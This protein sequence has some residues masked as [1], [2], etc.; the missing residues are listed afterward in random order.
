MSPRRL[1]SS[2]DEVSSPPNTPET[3]RSPEVIRQKDES[4]LQ[5]IDKYDANRKSGGN[6]ESNCLVE[7]QVTQTREYDALERER[8]PIRS[9]INDLA[10]RSQE[11]REKVENL[12]Y[13]EEKSR[14]SFSRGNRTEEIPSINKKLTS[15]CMMGYVP[16]GVVN[17]TEEEI[18][19]P[20]GYSLGIAVEVEIEDFT[21]LERN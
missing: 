19:L 1:K 11:Y 12:I 6:L 2:G 20:K 9:R 14:F 5:S 10:N 3:D 21:N 7:H 13:K 17:L 16:V 4:R 8:E 18:V 15:D